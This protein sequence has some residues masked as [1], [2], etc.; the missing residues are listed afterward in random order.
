[1]VDD[2]KQVVLRILEDDVD[3]LVLQDD[4]YSMHDIWVCK[5]CAQGHLAYGGL[6]DARVLELAFLIRLES[7]RVSMCVRMLP[8]TCFLMA[9]SP[10]RPFLPSAL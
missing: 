8:V 4:L 3:A 2:L 1:M 10:V 9:N 5:L 6:R 7:G